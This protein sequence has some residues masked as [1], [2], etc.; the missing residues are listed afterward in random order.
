MS[1][2][3]FPSSHQYNG[4]GFDL[5]NNYVISYK[6]NADGTRIGNHHQLSVKMNGYNVYCTSLRYEACLLQDGNLVKKNNTVA[7]KVIPKEYI[8]VCTKYQCSRYFQDT[9]IG[10]AVNTMMAQYHKDLTLADLKIVDPYTGST[11]TPKAH[12]VVTYTFE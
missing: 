8:M 4:Y 2:V 11:I 6:R 3:K 5:D 9:D 1:I 12:S 7:P 10:V